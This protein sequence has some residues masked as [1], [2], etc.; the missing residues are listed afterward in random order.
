MSTPI[1]S[2]PAI[3]FLGHI[4]TIDK[5]LPI[6]SIR[7]LAQKYGEIFQLNVLG[8]TR[9]YIS[10]Y[11]L[12]NE[13]CD[14]KRF[15]KKINAN[16]LQARG[17]VSDGLF[18]AQPGEENW[19]IAHRLLM[20]CFSPTGIL[21][22]Y[23][24]M[25]DVVSQLTMKWERFGPQDCIDPAADFTR[26]TLDAICLCA[27]S[28]RWAFQRMCKEE[29][30]PFASAMSDF[31]VESGLRANRLS[32]VQAMMPST[33]AKYEEDRNT[34]TKLA[35]DIL[36]DHRAHPP[37]QPDLISRMVSGIDKEAG[38]GLPDSSIMANLL[39]FLVAGHETTSGMLT[40][41]T[42]Y[43]LKNP[44]AMRK[45]REEIDTMVGDRPPSKKD[46]NKLP[47]LLAVMRES[48]RLGPPASLR[49]TSPKEETI[50]GGKY[51]LGKGATI[52]CNIY[53]I[54]RD[55][56]VWGDD[57]ELFRP[58][59][60]LDGKFEALP[61][62]AWQPFGFGMRA[63]IGRAFSWQ[64]VQLTMIS[65]FQRF[66]LVMRDPT[67]ELEL[68]QTLTIKP[69]N[70]FIHAIPRKDRP[71]LLH[72]PSGPTAQATR[73]EEKRS[74]AFATAS[75]DM[76][77]LYV[78]YGS[79]T[80]TS[81][82]FAQRLVSAAPSHGFR[83]T[84]ETLDKVTEYLPTNGP[85]LIV[86]ASYEGQPADNARHF[87]NYL[88]NIKASDAFKGVNYSVFG[89]GNR[90]WT[91]TYQRIPKLIDDI[92]GG[93][94][95]NRL[96]PRGE[97]DVSGAEFFDTFDQWENTEYGTSTEEAAPALN[98]KTVSTGTARAERLRQRDMGLGTV[99]DTKVLTA[100]GA[101]IK[102]HIEFKLSEGA[103][104]RA[105]DYLAILPK[106]PDR[107]VHRAMAR[108]GLQEDMEIELDSSSPTG[109]VELQQ[110][111]RTRDLD[112]LL[113]AKNSKA[114][115]AALKD[116]K[117]N[118][119][120][121]V[122]GPR[123][124]V[125][126][127]L[128]DNKAIDLPLSTFLTMLPAMRIR[129]YSISSSPLW[130]AEHVTL[131]LS[132]VNAPARSGRKE[133]FLG[134]AST[135]LAGL[136][137]GD[138]VQL[139][140]RAASAAFHP[141]Q[142]LTVPLVMVCA[143]SGLAPMRGFLQER[144]EQKKAGREV[145]TSLLF[146]GCRAPGEDSSTWEQMGIVDVRVAFSRCDVERA[147]GCKYVQDRIALDKE[148]IVKSFRAGAKYY[149]CG[150]SKMAAGAKQVFIRFVQETKNLDEAAATELFTKGL[151][152]RYATDVFE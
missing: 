7:L 4:H 130:D 86:T 22:M 52:N 36:D 66:D 35:Q 29:P 102:M 41:A 107:I 48:L 13:V 101:P 58:E 19:G 55:P 57:A 16:L 121:K 127:I 74:A 104:Y 38:R 46:V 92:L 26:L 67:Y 56:A 68:K 79:N 141:P 80:G 11:A 3:P 65:I 28:Y 24:G 142:D 50:L 145:A 85:V 119:T 63:C 33:N 73:G 84:M 9:F 112:I 99:V 53:A 123:L 98:I 5:Q 120:N 76:K 100:S 143:G 109:Y 87:V 78:L 2:P 124:S 139:A 93:H 149:V 111:A 152:D 91:T 94:G 15:E 88:E 146:Y 108:F 96:A 82:S 17:A 49:T 1:P 148:D 37:K 59:R 105:G 83:A 62:N 140:V 118:Y 129:Q 6:A 34:M 60:M 81:E 125:L 133:K 39:T 69:H 144:A 71:R 151:Q 114:S 72:I 150:S 97:G 70:F 113:Q 61:P 43:L 8:D 64:E 103:T 110:P 132:V 12:L 115:K 95:A 137:P 89:C 75:K 45:L 135:F 31:L 27:M 54:H 23:D 90:D 126:D 51:T 117:A 147:K 136:R 25:M 138:K 134:V 30:H 128:E 14:D 77:P 18:T 44:E 10:T 122:F 131:T 106:N 40:F 116:L 21:D 32:I 20:P 47:Y 42:Y